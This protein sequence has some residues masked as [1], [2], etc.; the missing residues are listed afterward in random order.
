MWVR[1][2]DKKTPKRLDGKTWGMDWV[3]LGKLTPRIKRELNEKRYFEVSETDPNPK[4]K[5]PA[6]VDK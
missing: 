5:K 1:L 4:P 3:K 6:K 2:K